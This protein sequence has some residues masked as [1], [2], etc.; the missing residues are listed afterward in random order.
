MEYYNT[1]LQVP[2]Y[3]PIRMTMIESVKKLIYLHLSDQT[4][5]TQDTF[6]KWKTTYLHTLTKTPRQPLDIMTSVCKAVS[7][8]SPHTSVFIF[9]SG[10]IN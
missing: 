1:C 5:T 10:N 3:L 8:D 2:T 6:H 7:A 9:T 4:F